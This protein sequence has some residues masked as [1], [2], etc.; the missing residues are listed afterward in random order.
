ME[1]LECL[2]LLQSVIGIDLIG[3][4]QVHLHWSWLKY[5]N[6]Y[7]GLVT[8]LARWR[9]ELASPGLSSRRANL[10]LSLPHYTTIVEFQYQNKTVLDWFARGRD[11]R[12]TNIFLFEVYYQ[13]LPI[14]YIQHPQTPL[15]LS[16]CVKA[17]EPIQSYSLVRG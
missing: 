14:F 15:T 16:G 12:F 3:C 8:G 9:A 11:C 4:L 5:S 10:V 2:A 13:F 7:D 1:I 17:L 6:I